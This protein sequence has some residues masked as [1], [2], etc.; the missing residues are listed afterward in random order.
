MLEAPPD[1]RW[2]VAN[3]PHDRWVAWR[4]RVTAILAEAD[5]LVLMEGREDAPRADAEEIR[6]AERRAFD[7]MTGPSMFAGRTSGPFAVRST[8]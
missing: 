7:E 2:S 5:E 3:W 1:W 6:A 8:S 4:Q